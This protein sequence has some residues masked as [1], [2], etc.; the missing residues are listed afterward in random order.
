MSIDSHLS[1]IAFEFDSLTFRKCVRISVGAVLVLA[2]FKILCR[3][4][5][6]LSSPLRDAPGPFMARF[7]RLWKLSA[8]YG[9]RFEEINVQLHQ[10]YGLTS[11]NSCG[12]A[13]D[14]PDFFSLGPIVRIAP[15]EYSI[16]DPDA[17]SIIYGLGGDFAK[18]SNPTLSFHLKI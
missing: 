8:I 1:D 13:L 15:N 10:K 18:V 11:R 12:S 16:D 5:S 9:G 3:V 17:V 6:A 14:L 2:V 4:Y 7:T